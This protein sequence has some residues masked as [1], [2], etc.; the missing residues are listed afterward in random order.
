ME[1]RSE[2][3][4]RSKFIKIHVEDKN[5]GIAG[6]RNVASEKLIEQ[7][8]EYL[9]FLD[10]DIEFSNGYLN[11]IGNMYTALCSNYTDVGVIAPLVIDYSYLN[12]KNVHEEVLHNIESSEYEKVRGVL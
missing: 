8:A 9:V 5:L 4:S 6:A 3:E 11:Q 1:N 10:N 7:H 2:L 12:T